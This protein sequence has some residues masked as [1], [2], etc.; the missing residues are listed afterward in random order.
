MRRASS[1]CQ[2]N[3]SSANAHSRRACAIG[4]P[5]SVAIIRAASSVR[6]RI[7]SATACS[8]SAR[9]QPDRRR[10][11]SKPAAAASSASAVSAAPAAGARP[12]TR[13]ETG[14][15]TS[16]TPPDASFRQAPSR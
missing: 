5:V 8:A 12:T 10:H 13:P 1:A 16:T 3:W 7:A 9:S 11:A 6:P 14:L 15:D 4:L 2:R